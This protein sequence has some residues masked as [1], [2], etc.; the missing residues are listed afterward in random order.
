M[1]L[2]RTFATLTTLFA[3][4]GLGCDPGE[5]QDP[6]TPAD[7]AVLDSLGKPVGAISRAIIQSNPRAESSL[8]ARVEVQPNEL[9][10]FYEPKPGAL[11]VSGARAS[12]S[13][14][15]NRRPGAPGPPGR[16]SPASTRRPVG[17]TRATTA[18]AGGPAPGTPSSPGS[19]AWTTTGTGPGPSTTTRPSTSPTSA[20]PPG[21]SRW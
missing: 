11:I 18:T 2:H 3:P 20:P 9:L 19:S 17:A 10:E 12:R 16:P 8:L 1:K 4:F 5:S 13:R 15:W 21:R 6:P 14:S 7:E